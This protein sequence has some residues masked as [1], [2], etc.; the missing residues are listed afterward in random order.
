MK[1]KGKKISPPNDAVIIIP[2]GGED[3]DL[4]F[5]ARPILDVKEFEKVC[6][7]PQPT[8]VIK[9]GGIEFF[10]D[11]DPTYLENLKKHGNLQFAWLIIQSLL[12]TDGFEWEE[13]KVNDPSTWLLYESELGNSGLS[14]AE[15]GYLVREVIQ[16]NTLD[17]ARVKEARD[18]FFSKKPVT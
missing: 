17:D 2:R 12:A 3:E 4:I 5:K 7:V 10:D 9:P 1:L 13:V 8:R 16:A 11:K 6:P 15:S 18:R 14:Q